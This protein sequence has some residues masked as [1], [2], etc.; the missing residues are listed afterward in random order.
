VLLLAIRLTLVRLGEDK[1]QM[2]LLGPVSLESYQIT[3]AGLMIETTIQ[4][5]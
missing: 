3:I 2:V 4:G 5:T 1:E